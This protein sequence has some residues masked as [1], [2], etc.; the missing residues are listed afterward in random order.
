M[1]NVTPLNPTDENPRR[2]YRRRRQILP[3]EPGNLVQIPILLPGR[4]ETGVLQ[5]PAAMTQREWD[6]LI[7]VIDAYRPAIVLDEDDEA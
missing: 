1:E 2:G 7:G 5:V 3:S 4:G 6:M